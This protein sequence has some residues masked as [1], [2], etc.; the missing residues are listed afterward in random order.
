[1]ERDADFGLW[2]AVAIIGS[3]VVDGHFVGGGHFRWVLIDMEL[4]ALFC[5]LQMMIYYSNRQLALLID[6]DDVKM[7]R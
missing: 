3:C 7:L 1:M 2:F 5:W 4:L 6:G